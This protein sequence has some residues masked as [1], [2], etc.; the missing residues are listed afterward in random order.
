MNKFIDTPSVQRV[1]SSLSDIGHSIQIIELKN[2]ARSAEDAASALNVE[3]GAI[4]KTLIFKLKSER[5]EDPVVTL[6][7][8]DHRCNTKALGQLVGVD[9]ECMR[10]NADEVRQITGYSIGG[11][12]PVGLPSTLTILMDEKLNRYETIWA[13]AGHPHCV[14][15]ITFSQLQKLTNAP[16]SNLI[17]E[18][19]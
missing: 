1:I 16:V 15:S 4:V 2:T 7:S 12:S 10:A 18:P 8:G 5:A 14:F 13:A 6:I 9:G 17:S 19:L 3:V 11:V